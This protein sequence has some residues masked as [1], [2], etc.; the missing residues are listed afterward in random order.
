MAGGFLYIY[1]TIRP[2]TNKRKSTKKKKKT[3]RRKTNKRK[4]TKKRKN[5]KTIKR[6]QKSGDKSQILYLTHITKL[7]NIKNILK[8]KK[9]LTDYERFLD[10][11][12]YEALMNTAI[13]Y[14]EEYIMDKYQFPGLY[15]SFITKYHT[16]N[17][18]NYFG[19][20]VILVFG[21][22]L[23]NQKNYH[24]NIIDSNGRIAE[25]LTYFPH[26]INEMPE[27]KDVIEF[28]KNIHKSYPGNEIVFHDG[29]S[30][31]LISKI[32]VKNKDITPLKISLGI[33]MS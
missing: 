19:G 4:S 29:I 9:I 33:K 16:N 18:I 27:T 2:K 28:Y 22:E 17:D 10:K 6:I 32:W 11:T 13:E 31:E 12:Q 20:D 23:L 1:M 15:L 30:T 8:S 3:I 25:N 5:K 7:S 26:N 21:K 14:D 24:A